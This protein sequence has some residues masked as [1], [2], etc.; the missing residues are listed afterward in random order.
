MLEITCG[1]RPLRGRPPRFAFGAAFV[2]ALLLLL[3]C[4]GGLDNHEL[5]CEEA[6]SRLVACCP[7]FDDRGITCVFRASG[8]G[9][10]SETHYPAISEPQSECIRATSCADLV[11]HGV[12]KRAESARAYTVSSSEYDT[13]YEGT[14]AKVCP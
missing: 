14:E 12:C 3:C 2:G 1:P 7:G 9:C 6:V 8:D 13:T 5:A 11:A 4:G 10:D